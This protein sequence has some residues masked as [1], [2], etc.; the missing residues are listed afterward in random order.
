MNLKRLTPEQAI[1][2]C[3]G[4]EK[5][6]DNLSMFLSCMAGKGY[7]MEDTSAA[8]TGLVRQGKARI[9]ATGP[10]ELTVVLSD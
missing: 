9:V 4:R 3:M 10:M 5:Q 6:I 8:L 2:A 1:M 7:D